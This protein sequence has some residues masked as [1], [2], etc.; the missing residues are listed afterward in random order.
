MHVY[1]DMHHLCDSIPLSCL[2]SCPELFS[3]REDKR[4]RALPIVR[5]GSGH[6][7]P[8]ACSATPEHGASAVAAASWLS[9]RAAA[10]A[11]VAAQRSWAVAAAAVVT[12]RRLRR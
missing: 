5:V 2:V 11:V 3:V 9:F 10:A 1:E 12:A 8:G 7:A 6:G 4:L